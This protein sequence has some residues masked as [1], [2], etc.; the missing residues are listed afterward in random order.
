MNVTMEK[1]EESNREGGKC[2][3]RIGARVPE[4]VD[5]HSAF[6]ALQVN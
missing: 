4:A 2:Q 5:V 1:E 6:D 3:C